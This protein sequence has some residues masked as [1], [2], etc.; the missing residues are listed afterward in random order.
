MFTELIFQEHFLC[1]YRADI[2]SRKSSNTIGN[3]QFPGK[4]PR[5]QIEEE[6]LSGCFLV[7]YIY[8]LGQILF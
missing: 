2:D 3:R 4:V 6:G 5:F 7:V 8:K 1:V